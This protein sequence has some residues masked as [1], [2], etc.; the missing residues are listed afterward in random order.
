MNM[1]NK[2]DAL[3]KQYKKEPDVEN[4]ISILVAARQEIDQLHKTLAKTIR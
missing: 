2:I 4:Q 3:I 1:N